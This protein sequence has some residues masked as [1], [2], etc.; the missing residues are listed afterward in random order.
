MMRPLLALGFVCLAVPRGLIERAQADLASTELRVPASSA[1]LAPD[2]DAA[3]V[4]PGREVAPFAKPGSSLLWF[5]EFRAPGAVSVG[6]ALTVPVGETVALRLTVAAEPYD[7]TRMQ[8]LDVV[9]EGSNG[10]MRIALGSVTIAGPGYLRFALAVPGGRGAPNVRVSA[11]LLD[12]GPA[13]DA[14]FNLDPRRNA[15]SV[16]LRYPIDSNATITGFY[17]EVTAVTDPVTTYYMATG[18]A[19]GYF[20]MQVNSATERRIIFSVWDSGEGG[21]ANDRS[22][23]APDDQT[24][25][26]GKGAGVVAE[27][28]GNEG[29]GGHSHLVYNWKTGSTQRFFVTA[30]IDGTHTIYSGYWFHPGRQRWQLIASF[31]APKDGRGLRRLYSFSENFDGATG[32]LVRKALFGPAWIRLASGDW[33][34]L[35]TTT[36]SHDATGKANRLDRLMGVEA[37]RFFLQHGGFVAGFTASGTAFTRQAT[38]APPRIDLSTNPD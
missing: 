10:A 20:G 17:N 24:Q 21:S 16:H 31:R 6:I 14:H 12:G 1:Y 27:V 25:L 2:P 11:L 19:R 13:A 15:A 5:G 26:L 22:T 37:G 29:T 18:F 36:F 4:A 30:A 23:V 38:G 9:G 32:H 8:A 34:E 7:G 33:E 28:F 35:T 3:D